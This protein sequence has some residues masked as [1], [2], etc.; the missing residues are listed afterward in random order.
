MNLSTLA[1]APQRGNLPMPQGLIWFELRPVRAASSMMLTIL[2]LQGA[3][4]WGVYAPG[5]CPGLSD[6][7]LAGRLIH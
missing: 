7:A 2:P 1:S 4:F 6:F 5:R 3:V